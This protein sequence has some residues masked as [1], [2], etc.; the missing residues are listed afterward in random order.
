MATN[1]RVASRQ[2]RW[3]SSVEITG[4]V[5]SEPVLA[6][7]GNFRSLD[8]TEVAAFRKQREIWN[9][10]KGMVEGNG[11]PAWISFIL[12][13]FLG[14]K[15]K[16]YWQV[17]A[18]IPVDKVANL[19]EQQEILRPSRV[20]LDEENAVML[21]LEVPREQSLDKPW[22]QEKGR[23][24]ASPTTKFERLLREAGVELGLLTNGEAWRLVVASPSETTSWMTWTAQTWNDDPLTLAAFKD[25]LGESRFFAGPRDQV[26]LELIKQSRKRQLDVA[27]QLGNQVREALQIL[28]HEF[29]RVDAEL[30]GDY[31]RGYSEAEMFESSVAFIMRLLFTLYAEE[32]GLLPHGNVTYDRAYGVLHLL[33]ELEETLRL[34]PEKLKYSYAGYARLLASSRLLHDGSV[35]PDIRI[36]AHGGQLFDPNRY[37]LLDGREKDGNWP[38]DI[39]EPPKVRDVVIRDILRSLKYAKVDGVRQL[40]SYRTLAVEQIGHMYEGLLDRRVARAPANQTLL[41]LQGGSKIVEPEP[42]NAD[43]FAGLEQEALIKAIAKYTSKAAGTIKKV[44]ERNE[45]RQTL[46]NIGTDD[47]ELLVQAKPVERFLQPLGILRPGGLYVTHGQDRRSSGAHYTPP[48]L[49]EPVVRRTLEHQVYVNV[50]GKPGLLLEPRLIKTPQEILSLKICDPAMGSGAFLVQATRYMA[51]RLVDA[52][53][54][55]AAEL[56]DAILTMPFST[57]S[58]G[59]AS[60]NLMPESREERLVF[61]RRYVAERCIY[62]VDMNRLAVEMAK[63]SLWLTTLSTDRPFTFVDHA[64]KHG[65]SLVG[66][67]PEQIRNFTWRPASNDFGP[68]FAN[69]SDQEVEEVEQHRE[70]IHAIPD[71]DFLAKE[72]E[73]RIAEDAL[74]SIRLKATLVIAAFFN[75]ANT[76]QRE[77]KLTEYSY[78]LERLAADER[79]AN[80]VDNIVKGL[81]T[82]DKPIIPFC[83]EV[84]FPEVFHRDN[85][86]FDA[87][88]GNPPFAGKNTTIEGNRNYFADWLKLMHEESH[89]NSDL[90]AHFFRSVF[91]LLRKQGSFGL[92]ATKTIRQG[93]TRS[94]ALRWIINHGGVIYNAQRRVPWPG[95]AAVIVSL[96]FTNKGK[97]DQCVYLDQKPVKQITAHLFDKG[98]S[99]DPHMLISNANK[100]F[101]GSYPLGMGFT[102]DDTDTKGVATSIAEM[103]RLIEKDPKNQDRIF[104]YIGG[105]EV[106]DSPTHEHHRYIIDFF[107]MDEE[108]AQRWPDLYNI[109]KSKVKPDRDKQKRPAVRDRWWQFCEKRPGLYASIKNLTRVLA[110]VQTSKYRNFVFLEK[111]IVYDQTLLIFPFSD[112]FAFAFLQ[113]SFHIEWSLFFG[114]T[115]EDRPRYTPSDCFETFPFSK[116]ESGRR[117]LTSIAEKLYKYREQLLVDEGI[118]FTQLYNL[119]H[120][121]QCKAE[122]I[123]Q[124]RKFHRELDSMVLSQYGWKDIVLEYVFESEYEVD[125][126]KTIPWRYRWPENIRD[127]ILARLLALNKESHRQERH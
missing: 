16:N 1:K 39:P 54:R 71:H 90:V 29:D 23:W 30:G 21:V 113:S 17:G 77:S 55:M 98:D 116:E 99:E 42:V 73:N 38:T 3:L 8:K 37:P 75:G 81:T 119:Y 87:F 69:Q 70:A 45:D 78:W 74:A 112:F 7:A 109:L 26:I 14:L 60:E 102:F 20:L 48:S 96:I 92:I 61:A 6:D 124:L 46:V 127:E 19:H 33:T 100:S 22:Q 5:L 50:E 40:V 93:D 106:N 108:Q 86:G 97:T 94:T 117:D 57:P 27:D 101:V 53:E 28:V 44:L 107:D 85:G 66:L 84:E 103:H 82:G 104:P 88:V 72:E 65:N 121:P 105:A 47:A 10:P 56:P 25:L 64:L 63:L 114:P 89:G 79:A 43:E 110:T 126:G 123:E 91:D 62:G 24:K 58:Q 59:R 12:E 2:H 95:K 4:V 122:N 111:G 34:A 76:K 120:N 52:W 31:L 35:D 15:D 32:N 80:E 41:L 125:D 115:L 51:E 9:L 13:D 11:Q 68:L 67:S 49:T 118:G 18:A 36:A 83:W